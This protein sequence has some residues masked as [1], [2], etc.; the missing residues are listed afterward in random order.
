[1]RK[2]SLSESHFLIN[3]KADAITNRTGQKK[4]RT[5]V[6]NLECWKYTWIGG[7][8]VYVLSVII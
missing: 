7:T 8:M 4:I 1:M 5:N 3:T 6:E 2:N